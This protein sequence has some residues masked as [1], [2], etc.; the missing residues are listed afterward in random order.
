MSTVHRRMARGG[1]IGQ[2]LQAATTVTSSTPMDTP[3]P[4]AYVSGD[5]VTPES[6][7]RLSKE[8]IMEDRGTSWEE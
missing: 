2:A 1:Q 5:E 4:Y 7:R 6:F 8:D 3:L